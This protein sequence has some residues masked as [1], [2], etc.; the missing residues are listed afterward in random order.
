M[1]Y[2]L[3]YSPEGGDRQ[4]FEFDADNPLN[5]EAEALEAVGGESWEDYAFFLMRI[6][7]GNARARHA[8]LWVML[9][10]TQPELRFVDVVFRFGEFVIEEAEE[11]EPV[12]KDSGGDS[13]T[14]SP[15]PGQDSE[16]STSS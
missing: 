5:L 1:L 13:S 6:G 2:R 4:E 10:R 3:V 15:S 8:L 11:S 7:S 14:D 12:G 16:A 9:R